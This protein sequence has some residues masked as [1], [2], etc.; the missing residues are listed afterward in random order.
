MIFTWDQL[1]DRAR[2]YCD[3]DH[4]ETP[5]WITNAKWLT[6][7]QVEYAQLYR[8]W[9]R[10]SLIAPAPVDAPFT[11]FTTVVTGVLATLGV[12]QD[13]GGGVVRLLAPAQS[14]VG[15]SPFWGT[16]QVVTPAAYWRADGAA[17]DLTFTLEPQDP[18]GNYFV[19]YIPVVPYVTDSTTTVDLPYGTD[20]RLVLGIARRAKLKEGSASALLERL[21]SDADQELAFSA[22]AR[23]NGDS[24]RVRRVNRN[25]LI[26]SSAVQLG[27]PTAPGL[28]RWS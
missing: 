6:L 2:T 19:R 24:P 25:T 13:K 22:F 5:G 9:L 27:F 1:I 28:W 15:R 8:R 18:S 20:E 7:A 14:A 23:V 3:D 12:A 10:S 16:S 11:G 26:H 17:N 21:L 4:K